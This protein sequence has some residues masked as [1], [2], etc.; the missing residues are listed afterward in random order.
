MA[1]KVL[2]IIN[3]EGNS[4]NID[5]LGGHRP[6]P[7]IAFLGRY[8]VIDFVMS[9][10]TNSGIDNVQVY[11]KEKPRNLMD[12]LGNGTHYN[13][14]SKRG[15][16]RV[17]YGEKVFQSAPYNTDVANFNLNMEYIEEAN[18]EYV[19][20]AP[21]YFV[22]TL[23]YAT[24]V[25]AH[26]AS[27]ADVTV[28]YTNTKEGKTQFNG[29]DTLTMDMDGRV[30]AV[31]TNQASKNN[32]YVSMECYV[33][34][35]S[36]FIQLCEEAAEISSLFWFKDILKAKLGT[37]TVK[38]FAFKGYVACLNSLIEY[39]RYTM[40]LSKKEN[41]DKLF[42]PG[43]DIYTKTNDSQPTKYCA[44]SKVTGSVVAN[45]C[46]IEGTVKNCVISRGVTI[47]KGAVV[48]NCIVLPGAFIGEDV[49]LNKVVV[50]K[51]ARINHVK[52]LAGTEVRPAYVHRR[53]HI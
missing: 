37:L 31:E 35:K 5:G 40:E 25:D 27:G 34:A 50:D 2:G 52:A 26:K 36:L 16:L 9:N 42:T 24:V 48:E 10:M 17:L 12:H 20:V 44:G 22:Y 15:K 6:V 30:L 23:D 39:Y 38:G 33:M 32:L 29:C 14:N 8:R 4:V 28:V 13:I 7:A 18:A 46:V 49:Q 41:A 1:D 53:D 51:F 3:F 21:S 19:V 43:W 45:G 47:K 11:C